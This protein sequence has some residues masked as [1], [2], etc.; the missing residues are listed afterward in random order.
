[1]TE[2]FNQIVSGTVNMHNSSANLNACHPSHIGKGDD[3][4]GRG[5]FLIFLV[6]NQPVHAGLVGVVQH[7]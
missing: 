4:Q 5:I 7:N 3:V 2:F 6:H 1:M